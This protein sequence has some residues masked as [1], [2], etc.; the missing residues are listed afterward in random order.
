[1]LSA[2]VLGLLPFLVGLFVVWRNPGYL[3]PLVTTVMGWVM[4]AIAVVLY[5]IGII[6]LRNLVKM[7][8]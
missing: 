7:E 6:W 1:M 5:V 3:E 4:I 8:V 2:W